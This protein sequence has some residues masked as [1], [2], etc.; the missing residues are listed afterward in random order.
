MN[1]ILLS[2]IHILD[3]VPPILKCPDSYA[4]WAQ[5]NQT[6]LHMH[7]NE[8]SVRLVVQDQSPITQISYDPPEARINLDSHVTVRYC[9]F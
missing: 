8:S 4:I 5:E 2:K 9:I 3:T 7:F 1:W 6:E